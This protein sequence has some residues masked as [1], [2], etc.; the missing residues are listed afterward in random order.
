[1]GQGEEMVLFLAYTRKML[2]SINI[3]WYLFNI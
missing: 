3:N 2:F 1:M